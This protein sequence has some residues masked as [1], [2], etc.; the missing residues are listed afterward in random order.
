MN[1]K[2]HIEKT[3]DQQVRSDALKKLGWILLILLIGVN[4]IQ[5]ARFG[6]IVERVDTYNK[7]VIDEIGAIRKDV[8]MFGNDLN[9]IRSFLLLPVKNYSFGKEPEETSNLGEVRNSRTE[10]AI[11]A[12]L[13]GLE[14][15][16]MVKANTQ[17]VL[18]EADAVEADQAFTEALH[19]LGLNTGKRNDN[20]NAISLKL[21]NNEGTSVF[22]ILFDKNTAAVSIQSALGSYRCGSKNFE[23]L[24]AEMLDYFGRNMQAALRMKELISQ[25]KDEIK[26]LTANADIAQILNEKKLKLSEAEDN[27]ES[28]NYYFENGAGDKIV[29]LKISRVDGSIDLEGNVMARLADLTG[30]VAEKLRAADASTDQEKMINEKKAELEMIFRQKSFKDIMHNSGLSLVMEP[31]AEINKILY[32][33]KDSSG[34]VVFS[35]AIE[36]SSGALKVIRG[37]QETDLYSILEAGSKKKP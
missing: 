6:G 1:S 32:D 20:D 5:L 12:F 11:Y 10:S 17:K 34:K 21:D 19:K 26:G 22:A 27:V 8:V 9:E 7:G 24:K 30:A 14:K 25:R 2:K 15:E 16:Q 31:R 4:T 36:V 37:N 13:E 33:V 29:T 3:S 18:R 28:V 23:E 35:F